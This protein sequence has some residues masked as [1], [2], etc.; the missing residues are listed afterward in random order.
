MKTTLPTAE[1]FL[2]QKPFINGMTREQKVNQLIQDFK[3]LW[4]RIFIRQLAVCTDV[5]L[6]TFYNQR[7]N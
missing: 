2:R 3:G 7:Y 5:Q 6:N 1:E 4:L